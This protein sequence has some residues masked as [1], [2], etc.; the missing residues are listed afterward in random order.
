MPLSKEGLKKNAVQKDVFQFRDGDNVLRILPPSS[1]YFTEDIDF[2]AYAFACH[3]NIG[4]EGS[5]PVVCPRGSDTKEGKAGREKHRCP[6][7][8]VARRLRRNPALKDL[9]RD[10]S[11]RVRYLMNV[12]DM[13]HP[14]RGIQVCE[15]GPAIYEKIFAVAID[16]DYGDVLDLRTGRN[17][18]IHLTPANKAKSGYNTYAVLAGANPSSV[19]EILPKDWKAKIDELSGRIGVPPSEEE[20]AAMVR[21]ATGGQGMSDGGE[22]DPIPPKSARTSRASVDEFVEVGKKDGDSVVK[23]GSDGRPSDDVDDG[24]GAGGDD[25][26]VAAEDKSKR[27]DAKVEVE[28]EAKAGADEKVKP[29][30]GAP[31]GAPGCWGQEFQPSAEKCKR[32]ACKHYESCVRKYT[33]G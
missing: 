30:D 20:L 23:R 29:M 28:V 10:L 25:G 18:K 31:A 19:K 12:L 26:L 16:K 32:A 5:P 8:D 1:R 21:E 6:I 4:P 9:A 2:I 22:A 15:V 13:E 3:Y 27:P 17:F 33:E 11:N 7:C 24:G 14:E